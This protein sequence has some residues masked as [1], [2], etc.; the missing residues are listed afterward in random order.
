MF[1][2][3]S[4]ILLGYAGFLYVTTDPPKKKLTFFYICR[5]LKLL[6]HVISGLRPSLEDIAEAVE[7]F[8]YHSRPRGKSLPTGF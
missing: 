6:A 1:H 5:H 7:C 3:F 4:Q 2:V 8:L